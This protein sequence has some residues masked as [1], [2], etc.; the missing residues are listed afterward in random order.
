MGSSFH[1]SSSLR[2][3]RIVSL[4]I[5]VIGVFL[6]MV[7]VKA[8]C[9]SAKSYEEGQALIEKGQYIEAVTFFDRCLHWYTP[10]NSYVI[11]S[12]ERLWQISKVA[13]KNG[14][15]RLAIIAVKTLRRGFIGARSF[16]V[17]GKDWIERCDERIHYLMTAINS[18]DRKVGEGVFP[19]GSILDRPQVKGPDVIW[20]CTMLAGF[21]GWVG[22][23]VCLILT[24]FKA[25]P[26]R[27]AIN[28][29]NLR[30]IGLWAVSFAIWIL[31]MTKA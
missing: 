15:I 6:F 11:K 4:T 25:V 7:W 1:C 8:F 24:G 21:L 16:Y 19:E 26:R 29:A 2:Y 20:T 28:F 10:F 13:E 12:A 23:F 3:L 27:S 5:V 18:K 30:W 31:G 14:D 22:A 17:P 9:G